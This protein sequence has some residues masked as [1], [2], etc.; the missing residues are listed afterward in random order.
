MI[1]RI[2]YKPEIRK[3]DV[4]VDRLYICTTDTRNGAMSVLE[5]VKAVKASEGI[6]LEMSAFI[7]SEREE[8]HSRYPLSSDISL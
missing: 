5:L 7:L 6:H 4:Y 3:Y 1:G 8:K 2:E